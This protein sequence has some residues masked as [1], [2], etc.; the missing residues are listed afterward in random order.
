MNV[1]RSLTF[2]WTPWSLAVVDR[3]RAGHGRASASSPGGGAAIGRRSGCSSCCGSALVAL[4]AVLL[5]QPE[6]VEE[7]RPEEKPSIAVLWD[8][9]PSMDTRDVVRAEQADRAPEHPPRGDRAAGRAAV[10]GQAPR[11]D[12][13]RHPAVLRRAGRARH[14]PVRP[15]RR[16]A[17]EDPEPAR[18]RAGL[19]RRLERG[20]AAGPGRRPAA[21]EGRARLRRAGRQPDA[22]ARRRAAQ[23][24]RPDVRRRR[25]VGAHPVHDRELAA[26][27]V[28]HDGHAQDVRRRRGHQGSP[29]RPDG[30]DQRLAR[31]EAEGDRRLHAHARRAQARRR[32]R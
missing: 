24:R 22:A 19:R 2:L 3:G 28:R 10:V 17:R 12:E 29:D 25:Q 30:P 14:R 15:A 21:D 16:G 32:D 4:V 26:A 23:P 18:D 8:A 6:W 27:R 13:R 7:Y 1:S 11:A 20:P 5:N 31:L 9:S